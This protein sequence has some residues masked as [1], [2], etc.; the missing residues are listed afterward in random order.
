MGDEALWQD[1]THLCPKPIDLAYYHRLLQEQDRWTVRTTAELA[2]F[3]GLAV[4]VAA[5]E[6]LRLRLRESGWAVTRDEL[7]GAPHVLAIP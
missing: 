6:L 2:G 7:R 1:T 4:D 5:G 3:T